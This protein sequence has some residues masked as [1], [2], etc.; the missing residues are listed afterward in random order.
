EA[1]R[2]LSRGTSSDFVSDSQITVTDPSAPSGNFALESLNLDVVTN[3]LQ[4]ATKTAWH[5]ASDSHYYLVLASTSLPGLSD[6]GNSAELHVYSY[7]TATLTLEDRFNAAGRLSGSLTAT[8]TTTFVDTDG[9][10]DSVRLKVGFSA[11]RMDA[12]L[13]DSAN[14]TVGI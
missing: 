6:A 14:F 8:A 10:F 9:G 3:Q 1:V 4:Y 5:A 12:G 7:G 13:Q 11:G 2:S